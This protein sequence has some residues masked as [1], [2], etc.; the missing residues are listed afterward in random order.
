MLRSINGLI[1]NSGRQRNEVRRHVRKSSSQQELRS[2][3]VLCSCMAVFMFVHS[4]V[5]MLLLGLSWDTNCNTLTHTCM[6]VQMHKANKQTDWDRRNHIYLTVWLRNY[7]HSKP[8]TELFSVC[9]GNSVPVSAYCEQN[10]WQTNEKQTRH[11]ELDFQIS[12]KYIRNLSL[13]LWYFGSVCSLFSCHR[14]HLEC[15]VE[16]VNL[17]LLG[18]RLAY[19]TIYTCADAVNLW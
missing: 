3:V 16:L 9:C 11:Q 13:F 7:P 15:L 10:C 2:A 17:D 1:Q 18:Q 8:D 14:A 12:Y 6:H 5:D 19:P 4:T